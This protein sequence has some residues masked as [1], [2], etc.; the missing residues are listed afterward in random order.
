[1]NALVLHPLTE[2]QLDDSARQA[3]HGLLLVGPTGIGKTATAE[4]LAAIFLNIEVN[5]LAGYAYITRI[6]PADGKTIGIESVRKLEHFLSL[7]VPGNETVNRIVILSDTQTM[8]VEAQN[9][10][11]KTLEEP[12]AHTVIIMTAN[13]EQALLPTVRSRLQLIQLHRPEKA[14]IFEHFKSSDYKPDDIN[15]MFALTGGLPGLMQAL[16]S[17]EEHPLRA[18]TEIARD[19]LKKPAYE[20]LLL[21]DQLAK[22]RQLAVDTL[23]ILQQMAHISLHTAQT[24][25]A[26]RWQR[27]M[28]ASFE[29]EA[30]LR[31]SGQPKLVLTELFVSL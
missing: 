22:D 27:V 20:R 15:R 23:G 17:D 29:A 25:A 9:A 13:S 16:L 1:M 26:K 5:K 12:P 6:E 4:A 7:K 28:E 14:T 18:A 2:S 24:T 21:V 11:L 19:I 3:P 30:A 31:A 8:T 10:L